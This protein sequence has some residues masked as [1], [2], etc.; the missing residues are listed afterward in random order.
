MNL[1]DIVLVLVDDTPASRAHS[2]WFIGV[3]D[4]HLYETCPG[5]NRSRRE[6]Q[7]CGWWAPRHTTIDPLG[8]DVC[9]W[10][11]RVWKA[12]NPDLARGETS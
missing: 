5:L 9:G 4:D 10:C 8:G 6:L 7:R 12:R 11:V 2:P 1:A 3:L